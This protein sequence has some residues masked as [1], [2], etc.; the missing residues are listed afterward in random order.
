MNLD[1]NPKLRRLLSLGGSSGGAR[2]PIQIQSS[3]SARSSSSL[4]R[5]RAAVPDSE[6]RLNCGGLRHPPASGGSRRGELL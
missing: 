4:T 3:R 5:W 6:R 2:G 1:V